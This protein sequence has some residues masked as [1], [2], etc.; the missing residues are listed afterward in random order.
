M[1][2]EISEMKPIWYYVGVILVIIGILV[3]MAGIYYLFVPIPNKIELS[4]LHINI[5]WSLVLIISGCVMVYK[6]KKS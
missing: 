1:S 5:W 3:L 4:N 2:D 6:N